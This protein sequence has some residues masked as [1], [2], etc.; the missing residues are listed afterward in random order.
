[1]DRGSLHQVLLWIWNLKSSGA[2]LSEMY[3]WGRTY[4]YKPIYF[5]DDT[6]L[7]RDNVDGNKSDKW[8]SVKNIDLS[9]LIPNPENL[10]NSL[11]YFITAGR[12]EWILVKSKR[13]SSAYSAI[14]S[15]VLYPYQWPL[16]RVTEDR[17][18]IAMAKSRGNKGS[19]FLVPQQSIKDEYWRLLPLN[20]ALGA[21]YSRCIQDQRTAHT[22]GHSTLS[23]A[24]MASNAIKEQTECSA[25]GT[26]LLK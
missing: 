18:S 14:F 1:M 6:T 19:P 13:T 3:A 10:P 8:S 4:I 5:I 11:A 12:E 21:V 26:C 16:Q 20:E 9:Q 17:D 7:R 25:A 22:Y 2:I 24:L 15:S 23:K